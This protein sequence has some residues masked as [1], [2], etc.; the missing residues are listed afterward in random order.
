[1]LSI[2]ARAGLSVPAIRFLPLF[3][4]WVLCFGQ[5]AAVNGIVTDSSDAVIVGARLEIQNLETGLR[6]EAQTN[7]AGAFSFNLL[8]V[9]RYRITAT[10]AGFGASERPELK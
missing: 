10:H 2:R 7:E 5:S 6:R 4:P 9:G 8:P 3:I 1:M